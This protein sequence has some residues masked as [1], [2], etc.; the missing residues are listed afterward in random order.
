M[1]EESLRE[2][3]RRAQRGPFRM[4]SLLEGICVATS[5]ADEELKPDPYNLGGASMID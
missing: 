4:Y 5:R 1:E 2:R 3:G